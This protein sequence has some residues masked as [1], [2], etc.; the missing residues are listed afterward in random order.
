MELNN[1]INSNNP[2]LKKKIFKLKNDVKYLIELG[3]S[4]LSQDDFQ[5]SAKYLRQAI[6]DLIELESITNKNQNYSPKNILNDLSGK[7]WIRKTKS[8]IVFDGKPTDMPY[9]IKNHPASF[10]PDLAAHFIEFFTKRNQWVVDPFMGIGSTLAAC[11]FLERNCWG[12]ELNK[13]YSDYA[14]KRIYNAK[15]QIYKS[16]NNTSKMQ[17]HKNN[18]YND[19]NYNKSTSGTTSK[20]ET[21]LYLKSFNEDARN[22]VKIWRENGFPLQDFLITSP[23]YWNILKN[24]RGGVESTQKKRIK[25]GLDENYSDNPNDLSNIKEYDNYLNQLLLIFENIKK[26]MKQNAYLC[27]IIQNIRDV[28][29]EMLPIAWDL[30]YKLR[31]IYSLRQEFIWCQDKKF[32]GIWGYPTTYISNVHH[33]YCLIFQKTDN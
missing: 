23:P 15:M 12:T 18:D 20:N 31:S 1:S 14:V 29:G 32:L 13:R 9:E 4:S 30:A 28:S 21:T 16:N 27:I 3:N 8:W 17:N 11:Q 5:K 26:I 10:P 7:Q 22:I 6:N 2:I 25:N 24:S 19:Y 33:H